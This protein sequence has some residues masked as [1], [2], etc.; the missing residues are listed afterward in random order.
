MTAAIVA[1]GNELLSGTSTE[2]NSQYI[3]KKLRRIGI[4]VDTIIII[5]DDIPSIKETL[6]KIKSGTDVVL[7]TGGLGPTHDDITKEAVSQYFKSPL[8]F[9]EEAFLRIQIL[10]EKRGISRENLNEQQ[11]YLPINAEI[12]PNLEGTAQGMK[13]EKGETLFYFMPGV[14]LEMKKMMDEFIGPE[15]GRISKY[16][17]HYEII[18]TTGLSESAVYEK[19]KEWIEQHPE[20]ST[21]ILPSFPNVD[22][23]ITHA[24]A[25]KNRDRFDAAIH[26]LSELLGDAVYGFGTDALETVIARELTTRQM[27]IAT[28]ESCTGGLIANR[29]TNVSGSS[30][31]FIE[32]VVTYSNQSKIVLLGVEKT[33]IEKFGAVSP[34]TAT[35]MA[36]N[37]RL[38]AA[39]DIGLS[40]TGI[41]GPA[42]GTPQKPVGTVYIGIATVK[43]SEIFHYCYNRDRLGN[44][45]YFA[46][47]ALNQLRLILKK[48][49][50]HA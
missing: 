46:N 20:F 44:K 9:N 32:G 28:A 35:E 25:Q 11:A 17:V 12:I 29:L 2:T 38:R 26:E 22:I 40:I 41:A 10:F 23:S 48:E 1:I 3:L 7:V 39:T 45:T 43:R 5:G 16:S 49:G 18:H 14:P 15:L 42:G 13:F 27:T 31:Y 30:E 37:I 19:I 24:N 6:A 47:M 21:S 36:Q 50:I 4:T 34:E 8:K 33:T